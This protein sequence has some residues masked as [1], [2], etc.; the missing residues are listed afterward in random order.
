MRVFAVWS[1]T[2]PKDLD[3][4]AR[5]VELSRSIVTAAGK[6]PCNV[7]GYVTTAGH[8]P[9]AMHTTPWE[10]ILGLGRE[11]EKQTWIERHVRTPAW[12]VLVPPRAMRSLERQD[13]SSR[14]RVL[15]MPHGLLVCATAQDPWAYSSEDAE[16]VERFLLPAFSTAEDAASIRNA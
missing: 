11:L 6:L 13:R 16:A 7:G 8:S 9:Y 3:K 15:E 10:S 1:I 5:I 2:R 12:C 4:A 14:I